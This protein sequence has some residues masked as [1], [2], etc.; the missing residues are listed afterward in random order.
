MYRRNT[1]ILFVAIIII[2]CLAGFI[3]A[4]A[5]GF[6]VY[7]A[8]DDNQIGEN[9]PIPASP[10]AFQKVVPEQDNSIEVSTTDY[11][12]SI[13]QAVQKTGPAVVTV[14]GNIPGQLTVFGRL[15]DQPV[16]GSGVIISE[17]GYILTNNHVI[18]DVEQVGII[19]ANGTELP[20]RVIG[21]EK[22]DDLA[23]L[24]I[25]SGVP[26]MAAFGNSDLLQ[27]GESVIAIGSPLGDFKN[28]VTVGVVSATGRMLD[29]GDGY[30]IENLIQTDAAINSGNSGGP[31]VNL[32]G[33][34][35]GINTLII[36]GSY[37]SS[38]PAEG[39]GFAVPSNTALAVAEQIIRNGYFSRPSL[40]IRW[41]QITPRIA[42]T[43][44]LPVEWGVYISELEAGGAAGKYQL[45]PGDIITS[46]G[47]IALNAQNSFYN[48]LFDFE[49]GD[50]VTVEVI[51][52]GERL[53][54]RVT[55]GGTTG[56]KQ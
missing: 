43:Y 8:L 34:V 16:S 32:A 45:Q 14:V 42:A 15:P 31:L 27:P 30:M 24:K 12:T 1:G 29:S 40:G 50:E 18:E 20:A 7:L 38:A 47:G 33:E 55:L 46:I 22:F 41:I 49:A 39:L 51:R 44:N 26:G 52:L 48:T 9:T 5:G 21:T 54:F 56:G 37:A 19:L 10:A 36:R 11:Q 3:G 6:V 23:V 13:T 35:V 53:E 25:D 17:E 28:T 4:I 2:S